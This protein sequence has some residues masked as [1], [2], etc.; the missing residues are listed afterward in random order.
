[1]TSLSI[2]NM[3]HV[4][5]ERELNVHTPDAT[6]EERVSFTKEQI[7]VIEG[8]VVEYWKQG[9]RRKARHMYDTLGK[10]RLNL[11][12]RLKVRR[13]TFEM[14]SPRWCDVN[15]E[16]R[17]LLFKIEAGRDYRPADWPFSEADEKE[18]NTRQQD[19]PR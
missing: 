2:R 9:E 19:G 17:E 7:A 14:F 3:N 13:E 8:W 16:I 4:L 11:L 1:M 18:W 15:T 5:G 12:D 6:P 10:M